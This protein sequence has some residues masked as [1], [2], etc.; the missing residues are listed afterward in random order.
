MS[1]ANSISLSGIFKRFK[2]HDGDY[3]LFANLN[4]CFYQG[5]SYALSGPSGSGKTTLLHLIAGIL[6]PCQGQVLFNASRSMQKFQPKIGLVFQQPALIDELSALE[7]V[8]MGS[9]FSSTSREDSELYAQELL[10]LLGLEKYMQ[11][12]PRSLS[13]GQQQ[14]VALARALISKPD[15]LIADE[16]TAGLDAQS[17]CIVT[18]LM[19]REQ[20]TRGMGLIVGS[21][22]QTLLKTME[23]TLD[24]SCRETFH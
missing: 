9:F 6:K 15:F 8:V 19:I 20:Q 23:H 16:P 17:A 1:P 13:G 10:V 18:E 2:T 12:R 24:L 7:N 5:V 14:R 11:A 22:D 3:T 4:F 21:H